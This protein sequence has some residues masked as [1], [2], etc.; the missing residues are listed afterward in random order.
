MKELREE[1]RGLDLAEASGQAIGKIEL[2]QVRGRGHS[3]G[4]ASVSSLVAQLE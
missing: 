3:G 1:W 2:E 4:K